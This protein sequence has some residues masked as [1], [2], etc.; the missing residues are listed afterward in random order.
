MMPKVLFF[1][2]VVFGGYFLLAP[3]LGGRST[4]DKSHLIL[5]LG[6][7]LPGLAVLLLGIFISPSGYLIFCG[8]LCSIVG[9]AVLVPIFQKI[10]TRLYLRKGSARCDAV[11]VGFEENEQLGATETF[12]TP[13]SFSSREYHPKQYLCEGDGYRF[14]FYFPAAWLHPEKMS[15]LHVTVVYDPAKPSRYY[16][17][18]KSIRKAWRA[19]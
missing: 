10:E 5:G 14:T 15:G 8:A 4:P 19:K 2:L 13:F 7:F 12:S 1:I 9:L 11:V 6:F 17:V 16:V 18:R 3:M